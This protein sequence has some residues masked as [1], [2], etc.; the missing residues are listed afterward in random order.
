MSAIVKVVVPLV[1]T[2]TILFREAAMQVFDDVDGCIGNI[3]YQDSSYPYQDIQDNW[4]IKPEEFLNTLGAPVSR[5]NVPRHESE[6]RSLCKLCET[7]IS[8]RF[9]VMSILDDIRKKEYVINTTKYPRPT[10]YLET[11]KNNDAPCDIENLPNDVT[12]KCVQKK[13]TINLL[14]FNTT[15]KEFV[16]R[17]VN[18]PSAC[19]CVLLEEGP[20][21]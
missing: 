9:Q 19:E 2:I 12:T 20:E 15:S 6:A 11:C 1:L 21:E 16:S 13:T 14:T 10:I 7:K 4:K 8:N 3:C 18:Y 17:T 5:S